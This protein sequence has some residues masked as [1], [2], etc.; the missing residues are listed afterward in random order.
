MV[1]ALPFER[2]SLSYCYAVPLDLGFSVG[3]YNLVVESG[4]QPF[5]E[6]GEDF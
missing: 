2:T 1:F 3:Q 5:N 6:K 4:G